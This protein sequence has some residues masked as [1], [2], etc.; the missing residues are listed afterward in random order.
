MRI[1]LSWMDECHY[2]GSGLLQNSVC[3]LLHCLYHSLPFHHLMTSATLQQRK[4]ALARCLHL[5]IKLNQPPEVWASKFLLIVHYPVE[6][7]YRSTE[8]TKTPLNQRLVWGPQIKTWASLQTENSLN[9]REARSPC[10][11]TIEHCQKFILLICLP[12]FPKEMYCL[13]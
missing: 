5:D 9:K 13:L 8:W 3:S 11:R 7:C 1:P 4:K 10:G 2:Y 12:E 6:F